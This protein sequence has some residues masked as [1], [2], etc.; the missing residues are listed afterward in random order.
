MSE[1]LINAF[2]QI[3]F[4]ISLLYVMGWFAE[5]SRISGCVHIAN[6]CE[7]HSGTWC[8]CSPSGQHVTVITHIVCFWWGCLWTSLKGGGSNKYVMPNTLCPRAD[9]FSRSD[10]S[11]TTPPPRIS[12]S[13]SHQQALRSLRLSIP[14]HSYIPPSHFVH[15]ICVYILSLHFSISD[16]SWRPNHSEIPH[17]VFVKFQAEMD[18]RL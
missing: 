10:G 8:V 15:G 11:I 4:R 9:L 2:H 14:Q 5:F 18:A 1:K 7:F 16:C 3:R 17:I 13:P 12:L 6:M